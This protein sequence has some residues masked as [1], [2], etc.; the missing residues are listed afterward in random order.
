MRKSNCYTTKTNCLREATNGY[1]TN[2]KENLSY[3][4]INTPPPPL[5]NVQIGEV[6][7]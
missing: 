2:F 7:L 5:Y 1:L 3:T 6:F 4:H